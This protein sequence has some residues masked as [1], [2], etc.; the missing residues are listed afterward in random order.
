MLGVFAILNILLILEWGVVLLGEGIS[1][2]S[3]WE[4]WLRKEHS[5]LLPPEIIKYLAEPTD[6]YEPFHWD[7]ST[8]NDII[9]Y[10]VRLLA[11]SA[12]AEAQEGKKIFY[13]V[14]QPKFW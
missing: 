3:R 4:L 13:Q 5:F 2:S 9:S 1:C 7:H 14:V 12:Q 6:N 8:M 10:K 11:L